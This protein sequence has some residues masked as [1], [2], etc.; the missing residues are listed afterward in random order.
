M[1]LAA[2]SEER[3]PL[4]RMWVV[5]VAEPRP[6]IRGAALKLQV[7]EAGT[8]KSRRPGT[9]TGGS[10]STTV[11][12]NAAGGSTRRN[13]QCT[14]GCARATCSATGGAPGDAAGSATGSAA[15]SV[16]DSLARSENSLIDDDTRGVKLEIATSARHARGP[17][18]GSQG[19]HLCACVA[20]ECGECESVCMG[21]WGW[22]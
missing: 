1:W 10:A 6:G 2:A 21:G 22:V 15:G 7:H 20:I 13:G 18:D 9:A 4:L 12:S 19:C 11:A 17:G 16:T 5:H 14:A 3:L 8:V